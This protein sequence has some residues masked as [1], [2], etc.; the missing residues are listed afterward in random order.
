VFGCPVCGWADDRGV[1]LWTLR[2]TPLDHASP[3]ASQLDATSSER[4]MWAALLPVAVLS[5][6]VCSATAAIATYLYFN[7]EK[8]TAIAR[9]DLVR[10]DMDDHNI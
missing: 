7:S 1:K 3:W 8:V 5:L 2:P 4:I 9:D 6:L 10:F